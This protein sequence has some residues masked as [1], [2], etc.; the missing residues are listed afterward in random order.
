MLVS[1]EMM[2]I[3][4]SPSTLMEISILSRDG[5]TGGV[6]RG[7]EVLLFMKSKKLLETK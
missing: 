5:F 7:G 4:E 3:N 6:V 1:S 2:N